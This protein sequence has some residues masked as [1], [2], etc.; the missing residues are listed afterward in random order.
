M[1]CSDSGGDG[2]IGVRRAAE[3]EARMSDCGCSG[4]A[5]S[6]QYAVE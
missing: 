2:V 6:V 5:V 1:T 3:A 4:R